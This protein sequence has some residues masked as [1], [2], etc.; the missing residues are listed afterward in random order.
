MRYLEWLEFKDAM[1][2]FKWYP[3]SFHLLILCKDEETKNLFNK[4]IMEQ[5]ILWE[6]VFNTKGYTRYEKKPYQKIVISLLPQG[7][8]CG[9][10]ANALFIDATVS[11][12]EL[13][14]IYLPLVNVNP[15]QGAYVYD[16]WALEKMFEL[17]GKHTACD[18]WEKYM[19]GLK[20]EED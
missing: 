14:E 5:D 4:M 3:E 18:V 2:R 7:P 13:H 11:E 20:K 16:K 10:R 8:F 1:D 6:N 19:Y 15:L 9:V 12:D 17:K